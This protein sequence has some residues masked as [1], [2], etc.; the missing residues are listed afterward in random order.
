METKEA[1][2]EDAENYSYSFGKDKMQF[3]DIVLM[4]VK[5]IGDQ[6]SQEMRGGYWNVIPNS[7]P[8]SNVDYKTYIPDTREIYNRSVEYL[9]DILFPYFDEKMK[10]ASEKATQE[11]EKAYKKKAIF[12]EPSREDQNP[13]EAS[14]YNTNFPSIQDRISFRTLKVEINRILFRELCC[15]LYRKKYLELGSIED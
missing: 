7:N 4:H 8:Q 9:H 10:E 13:E 6:T 12:K 15:F 11:T 2:F 1:K 3:K 14:K 5:K